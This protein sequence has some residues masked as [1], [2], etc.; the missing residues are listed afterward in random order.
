MMLSLFT[1]FAF[2]HSI[3][4]SLTSLFGDVIAV[5]EPD[6]PNP[7]V[8]QRCGRIAFA[9]SYVYILFPVFFLFVA[10]VVGE[11]A[12][13]LMDV[14]IHQFISF[15]ANV[16]LILLMEVV[17]LAWYLGFN[18]FQFYTYHHGLMNYYAK[19]PPQLKECFSA[20]P[21]RRDD[22]GPSYFTPAMQS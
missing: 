20:P 10:A 8:M 17:T 16:P 5:T 15:K 19:L 21:A 18:F 3:W 13:L 22:E 14:D 7:L 11:V 12:W 9:S 6:L 1:L 4:T 2:L